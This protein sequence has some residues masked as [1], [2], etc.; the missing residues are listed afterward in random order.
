MARELIELDGEFISYGTMDGLPFD[1]SISRENPTA[2]NE[3]ITSITEDRKG[4]IFVADR[5]EL[6]EFQPS[7]TSTQ[8]RGRFRE[9]PLALPADREIR[10]LQNDDEGTLWIGTTKGLMRYITGQAV[11]ISDRSLMSDVI[12]T[13]FKDRQGNVW[14]GT[15]ADGGQYR[16]R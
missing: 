16:E 15:L 6:F 10:A 13:L 3:Q 2:A 5:R 11:A 7:E 4:Q 8:K 1:Q 12:M 14:V 9:L